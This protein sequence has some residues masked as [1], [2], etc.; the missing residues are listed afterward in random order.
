MLIS[1]IPVAELCPFLDAEIEAQRREP[2]LSVYTS[3]QEKKAQTLSGSGFQAST[4]TASSQNS[5][6]RS[7]LQAPVYRRGRQGTLKNF[8]GLGC[9]SS[10]QAHNCE[11]TLGF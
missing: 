5:L 4:Q 7:C 10:G 3:S 1:P 2:S 11:K 8:R 6:P 9:G